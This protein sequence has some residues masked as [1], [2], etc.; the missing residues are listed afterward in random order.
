MVIHTSGGVQHKNVT[1]DDGKPKGYS[2]DKHVSIIVNLVLSLS[3]NE[4]TCT[5]DPLLSSM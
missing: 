2:C 1:L 3:P 5:L 4:K